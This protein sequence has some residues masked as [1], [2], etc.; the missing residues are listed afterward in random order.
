METKTTWRE[1]LTYFIITS[2][3]TIAAIE[4]LIS[5]HYTRSF[6]FIFFMGFFMAPTIYKLYLKLMEEKDNSARDYYEGRVEIKK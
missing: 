6:I 4:G 2:L 5:D 3:F 1:I